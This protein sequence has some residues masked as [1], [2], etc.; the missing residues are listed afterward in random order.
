MAN[1]LTGLRILCSIVLLFTQALSPQFFVLYIAAG[2]TDVLDGIVARNLDR[3]SSFGASFDTAADICFF[4][5]SFAVLLP[6]LHLPL[7]SWL[8]VVAIAL[9]KAVSL[10]LGSILHKALAAQHTAMNKVT[11]I[12]LFAL[13]FTLS[14]VP[15][16][17]SAVPVCAVASFSAIQECYYTVAGKFAE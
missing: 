3:K 13:P 14:A 16:R 15:L 5:A 12:L 1:L 6:T 9:V 11:G 10:L 4:G 8:W 2:V 17:Y 7:W